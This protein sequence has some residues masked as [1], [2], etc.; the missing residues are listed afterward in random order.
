[1]TSDAFSESAAREH[2]FGSPFNSTSHDA[3]L[4]QRLL[5]GHLDLP[6]NPS[7]GLPTEPTWAENPFR[8]PNWVV[9]YHM[10]RWLDPLRRFADRGD[11]R[12]VELWTRL[13]TSWIEQ[14]PPGRGRANYSW[15]DMVDAMRAMTMCFALPMLARH[16][17]ATLPLVL[18]SL[19]EHGEWL[20]EDSHIKTGNHALQQHQGLLVMG[21]VLQQGDWTELA[22]S[23]ARN[24]LIHSY[25]EEGINEE[26]AVQYHQINYTWWNL[27]KRRIGLVRPSLPPEFARIELAPIGMAHATRPDGTYEMI[28]DTEV[29]RPRG[30]AHPAT[31]YVSSAGLSGEPPSDRVKVYGAGYVFGRSGWGDADRPFAKHS[32]YSVRFGPQN[33]IH[34]HV[35]G[36]SLTLYHQEAPVLID[37]GKY[38]YDYKDKLRAH[39]LSRA[40]HNSVVIARHEYDR[41]TSVD[42]V[43][44]A[45]ESDGEDFTLLDRGYAGVEIRRRIVVMWDLEAILVDDRVSADARVTATQVWHLDPNAGHRRDDNDIFVRQEST[46]TWFLSCGSPNEIE[47]V[48]GKTN[49]FQGWVSLG[50]REKTPTRTILFSQTGT[51]LRLRTL[52]D[53]SGQHERPAVRVLRDGPAAETLVWTGDDR[54]QRSV[55]LTADT[56]RT[57]RRAVSPG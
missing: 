13:V 18:R 37:T 15:A 25:D 56:F 11:T 36:G 10:L 57:A 29:F 6:P 45:L 54:S 31:E 21:A 24:M 39:L 41:S 23:R 34:G 2:A 12:G 43:H 51:D 48:R 26:G 47:V 14:N 28:G 3:R 19:Q 35:D 22:I 27:M 16:A 55:T 49:P 32:F 7:W 1:M 9:Q 17:P 20:A 46:R 30:V 5:D 52:I 8:E 33:R 50:W 53:F 4:V 38:T 44:A 42:L 40:A